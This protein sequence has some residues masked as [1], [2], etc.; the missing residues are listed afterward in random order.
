MRI[1]LY[2][3]IAGVSG[4]PPSEIKDDMNFHNDLGLDS[5]D[6]L[7]LV[8]DVEKAFRVS[9]TDEEYDEIHT[10]ANLQKFV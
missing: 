5:V 4:K 3:M 6:M 2:E 9:I 7:H 10:V 8:M 1:E